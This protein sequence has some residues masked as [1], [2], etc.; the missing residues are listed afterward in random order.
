M[1]IPSFDAT[2]MEKYIEQFIRQTPQEAGLQK[3]NVNFHL[4][5][6]FW[7]VN[8]EQLGMIRTITPGIDICQRKKAFS[9]PI[10]MQRVTARLLEEWKALTLSNTAYAQAVGLWKER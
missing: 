8:I 4:Y 9:L 3:P 1:E 7:A 5:E 2:K 6:K 10:G